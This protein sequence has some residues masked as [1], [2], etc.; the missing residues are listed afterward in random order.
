M[1]VQH[2]LRGPADHAALGARGIYKSMLGCFLSAVSDRWAR[3][4]IL[5]VLLAACR[6][7]GGAHD[8][9]TSNGVLGWIP[10]ATRLVALPSSF[11]TSGGSGE[12]MGAPELV[13]GLCELFAALWE[14]NRGSSLIA[15]KVEPPPHTRRVSLHAAL[16]AASLPCTLLRGEF[17]HPHEFPTFGSLSR[18]ASL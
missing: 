5:N 14:G 11:G 8:L 7:H 17:A 3:K 18:N 2:G 12:E 9:V 6:V 10:A 1:Y 13:R 16:H 15:F 4:A